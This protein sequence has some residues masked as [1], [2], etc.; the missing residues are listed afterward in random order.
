MTILI[1][2]TGQKPIYE[3][4]VEQVRAAVLSGELAAGEPLPSI[5]ALARE[6]RISVI[7]TKRAYDELEQEGLI[8]TMAGKG[9]F[10]AGVNLTLLREHR[11]REVEELFTRAIALAKQS[12]LSL[13][14]LTELLQLL[15]RLEQREE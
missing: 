2:N 6:L 11:L 9:S 5:R 12:G 4:I 10:V 1:S 14:E 8:Q 3:Q 13:T 15:Y 7:T